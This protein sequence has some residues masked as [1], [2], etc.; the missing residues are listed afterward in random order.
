MVFRLICAAAVVVWVGVLSVG[1]SSGWER[2]GCVTI[3]IAVVGVIVIGFGAIK[4]TWYV[5]LSMVAGAFFG[6]ALVSE[7]FNPPIPLEVSGEGFRLYMDMHHP[8]YYRSF[9]HDLVK[10]YRERFVIACEAQRYLDQADLAVRMAGAVHLPPETEL[11]S[12]FMGNNA[13]PKIHPCKQLMQDV[14]AGAPDWFAKLY[15]A[16]SKYGQPA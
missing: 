12:P 15:P 16:I 1:A 4:S 2:A 9:D 14:V 5:M 7:A 13:K 6:L 11:L 10:K 3:G 8:S